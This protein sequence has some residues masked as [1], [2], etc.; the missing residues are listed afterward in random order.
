M[1]IKKKLVMTF[2]TSNGKNIS[3]S[4]D[5]PRE[6]LTES[7]IKSAMTLVLSKGVFVVN[8]EELA[9]LVDA[10][11]VQTDTTEYDLVV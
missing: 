10:K 2:K 7:E 8:G 4:V 11:V 3:L 1:E 9:A 5:D 6:N